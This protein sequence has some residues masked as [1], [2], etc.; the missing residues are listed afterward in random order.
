MVSMHRTVI[1]SRLASAT[2]LHSVC[3]NKLTGR[4]DRSIDRSDLDH[5]LASLWFASSINPKCTCGPTHSDSFQ[6]THLAIAVPT[7]NGLRHPPPMEADGGGSG[8]S[9]EQPHPPKPRRRLHLHLI[10]FSKDRPFQLRETL[11][12]LR[13]HLRA[14]G[15][16]T[17]PPPPHHAPAAPAAVACDPTDL[18]PPPPPQHAAAAAAC[19]G[20]IAS[21]TV[22][23]AASEP[24]YH[25]SYQRLAADW[26]SDGGGIGNG[27]DPR[28]GPPTVRFV[29][30]GDGGGGGGRSCFAGLLERVIA[31][32]EDASGG[33]GGSSSSNSVGQGEGGEQDGHFVMWVVDDLLLFDPLHVGPALAALASGG[34]LVV[35]CCG[36][37]CWDGIYQKPPKKKRRPCA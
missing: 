33:G 19:D 8:S 36:C 30:E 7:N 3:D 15:G 21:L 32:L 12:S 28:F 18:D 6:H 23:H 20:G 14:T 24:R 4:I 13:T 11:R 25:A 22:I 5:R 26:S 29:D 16:P 31:G 27:W 34:C 9:G 10:A 2:R 35:F 17:N 37:G 1:Y